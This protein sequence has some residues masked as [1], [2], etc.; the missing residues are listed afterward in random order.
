MAA[1]KKERL[2]TENMVCSM[3][4][5]TPVAVREIL[6][7]PTKTAFNYQGSWAAQP[8]SR[9]SARL[10]RKPSCRWIPCGQRCP[11][12]SELAWWMFFPVS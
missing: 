10:A 8:G 1:K 4:G 11:P 7:Q 6:P 5:M 9:A 3:I 2:Y 12:G